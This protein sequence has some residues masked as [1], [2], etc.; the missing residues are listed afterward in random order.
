[1]SQ[2]ERGKSNEKSEMCFKTAFIGLNYSLEPSDDR[3]LYLVSQHEKKKKLHSI[4]KESKK[5]KFQLQL[6][7]KKNELNK[8]AT[9]ADKK[10]KLVK[11]NPKN[12]LVKKI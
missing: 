8:T 12:K 10:I 9:K 1:M 7:L 3:M 4:V 5:P 6:A 11:K 2:D